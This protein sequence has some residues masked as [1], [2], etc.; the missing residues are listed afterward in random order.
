MTQSGRLRP[1]GRAFLH[2]GRAGEPFAGPGPQV[3]PPT[4]DLGD[5][6]HHAGNEQ[7][8]Q[9]AD[10]LGTPRRIIVD[11]RDVGPCLLYTSDAADE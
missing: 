8:R 4:A 7:P 1:W 2:P 10:T 11:T 6:H 3:Q 5:Q 9:Q